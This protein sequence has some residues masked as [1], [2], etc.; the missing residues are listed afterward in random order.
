MKI[1]VRE[2]AKIDKIKLQKEHG[3]VAFVIWNARAFQSCEYI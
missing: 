1:N 3:H 2:Y